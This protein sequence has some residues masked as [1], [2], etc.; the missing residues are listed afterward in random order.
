[1]DET[2]EVG[3]YGRFFFE[4]RDA[5]SPVTVSQVGNFPYETFTTFFDPSP[6]TPADSASFAA[7]GT[8]GSTG[9]FS[10][11]LTITDARGCSVIV[12]LH[13]IVTPPR[14]GT[15]DREPHVVKR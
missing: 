15:S 13:L 5:R 3:G 7:F 9:D 11:R 6:S 1:M 4:L 12:V 14:S 2:V 8:A 10:T